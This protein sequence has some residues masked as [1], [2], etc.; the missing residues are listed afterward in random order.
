M[1]QKILIIEDDT[2][3]ARFIE[4]EL[5]HE[6][7]SVKKTDS[8]LEG[9]RLIREEL[10]NLVLLDLMLPEIDGIE[11]CSRIRNFSEIPIIMITARSELDDKIKGLDTGADDYLTKP[12][13]IEELLARIRALM[14]RNADE[15]E[16]DDNLLQVSDLTIDKSRHIVKRSGE[17]I[18]LTKKEYD[19]LTYLMENRDIVLS[20]EK[21]L[22]NVWGY[23]YTG[24]TNIVDVYIRYLRSKIDEPFSDRLIHT[25][26]GVGYVLR[27][28]KNV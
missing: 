19:L 16:G 23:N 21:L 7:Y 9:I 2:Q 22:N 15:K 25:V 26:R 17:Q 24:E 3:I 20:R 10:F 8:G 18:E 27:E 12:F 11:V 4:L 28:N 1:A 6:G 5:E 13:A 14:R